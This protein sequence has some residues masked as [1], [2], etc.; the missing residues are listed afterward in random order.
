MHPISSTLIHKVIEPKRKPADRFPALVLL[1]GRGAD[2]NDLLGLADYFDERLMIISARAPF[3]FPSGGGYTWYDVLEVGQPEP[4]MF[5]E[6]YKKLSQ[7]LEDMRKGYPVDPSGV[8]LCGFSMGSIMSFA[9]VLS[10]PGVASGVIANSGYVPEGTDLVFHWDQMK[11]K[12]FFVAHGTFDPVIPIAFARRAKEL[13]QKAG[14][15]LTYREYDMGH[16]I[17]EES[18]GEMMKW[19][20]AR[21]DKK[22]EP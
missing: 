11:G 15:A 16:Q 3:R 7:F 21:L 19:L 12:P 14:A 6:S 20:Q 13:L 1:H 17:G 9:L 4:A 22:R 8:I 5:A 2:E 18:L 10:S